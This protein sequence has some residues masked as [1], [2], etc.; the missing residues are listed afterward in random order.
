[1]VLAV[2][3]SSCSQS[4]SESSIPSFPVEAPHLSNAFTDAAKYQVD[5]AQITVGSL[6]IGSLNLPSGEVI[7]TD[8]FTSPDTAAFTRKVPPGQYPVILSLASFA[9]TDWAVIAAAKIDF[10][11]A[12][13]VTW[14]LAI[15]SGQ[16][17]NDLKAGELFGFPVDSGTAAFLSP[18]SARL[19]EKR[20]F[21]L[22]G[23]PDLTYIQDLSDQM[24]SNK[25]TGYWI[26]V[27]LEPESQFNAAF[28][29]SGY[30]DGFYAS[31]WGFDA[32]GNLACLV[33]DFGVLETAN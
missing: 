16:D 31:Y 1:M 26:M 7:A 10:T 9:D 28:F 33:T 21:R 5:G 2:V 4:I 17:P 11:G 29:S 22:L 12:E 27:D 23:I 32:A 30:G 15:V 20:L 6:S 14:Q 3:F 25:A 8:P 18:Q 13:P 19:H 24:D